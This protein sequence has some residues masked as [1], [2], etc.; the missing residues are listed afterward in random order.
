MA[1]VFR[2]WAFVALV[3]VLLLGSALAA[4]EADGRSKA[5]V[6]ISAAITDDRVV[7][8]Q[9]RVVRGKPRYRVRLEQRTHVASAGRV[10]P[11]W[12]PL[13]TS[14][15]LGK[16]LRYVVSVRVAPSRKVALR[17]VALDG[18][19]EVL[20]SRVIEI[21]GIPAVP[22]AGTGTPPAEPISAAGAPFAGPPAPVAV[23]PSVEPETSIVNGPSGRTSSTSATFAYAGGPG[24][25]CRVD[26]APFRSCP[27]GSFT[28][29]GL[30]D[31]PHT[32]EA[33]SV[34]DLGHADPTPAIRA[35]EI[36]TTAPETRAT[37]GPGPVTNDVGP[38]FRFASND[39]DGVVTYECRSDANGAFAPCP[40]D[41][42]TAAAATEGDHRLEV[43]AVDDVGNVDPTPLAYRWRLDLT[44]PDVRITDGPAGP[45]AQ[46]HATFAFDADPD[47]AR[48]ECR[49]DAAAFAAC[50]RGGTT[51]AGLDQGEHR[52]EVR[53]TDEAG[54]V[55]PTSVARTWLVDTLGPDTTLTGGPPPRSSTTSSTFAL[56]SPEAS[57]TRFECSLDGADFTSCGP[58]EHAL[59]DLAHGAHHLRV[60][61]LDALGN[62]DATPASQAF[63][64]DLRAPDTL[65]AEA[66]PEV[67]GR[68]LA[69]F[70]FKASPALDVERF[71]CRLDDGEWTRCSA[72]GFQ[73]EGLTEGDHHLEVRAT[74]SS[75]NVDATPAIHRWRVDLTAPDTE[76]V[77]APESTVATRTVRVQYRSADDDVHHFECAIDAG[78]F[79]PCGQ[80]TAVF[81][82]LTDGQ[83]TA[84]IRAVDAVGNTD[85]T[86]A[87]ATW[88]V[89]TGD[90]TEVVERASDIARLFPSA[91]RDAIPAA[92]VD[93][94]VG[95]LV[96]AGFR[97]EGGVDGS[98]G[99]S[100]ATGVS[101]AE[102]GVTLGVVPSGTSEAVGVAGDDAVLYADN[103]GKHVATRP[104]GDKA[105]EV[106]EVVPE[107]TRTA[108]YDLQVP[109]GARL[110]ELPNGDI[111]VV[112][113]AQPPVPELE[114]LHQQVQDAE[115][116]V[117][118][119]TLESVGDAQDEAGAYDQF[120]TGLA[121]AEGA[122]VPPAPT[123]PAPTREELEDAAGEVPAYV[124]PDATL[125]QVEA[126][127]EE[128]SR[129]LDPSDLRA[130]DH[131]AIAQVEELT[132]QARALAEELPALEATAVESAASGTFDRE[133]AALLSEQLVAEARDLADADL[134]IGDASAEQLRTAAKAVEAQ[135]AVEGRVVGLVSAPMSKMEDG[136]PLISTL[137]VTGDRSVEVRI[138]DGVQGNS[139]VD[140]LFVPIAAFVIRTAVQRYAPVVIRAASQHAVK[141]L[142]RVGS[143]ASRATTTIVRTVRVAQQA[144]RTAVQTAVRAGSRAVQNL[145]GAAASAARTASQHAA[146]VAEAARQEAARRIRVMQDEIRV[147]L[148]RTIEL[149]HAARAVER[150]RLAQLAEQARVFAQKQIAATVSR[151]I[152]AASTARR[153]L[154]E[155]TRTVVLAIRTR[156][157]AA[158]RFCAAARLEGLCGELVEEALGEAEERITDRLDG[159]AGN[160]SSLVSKC[161]VPAIGWAKGRGA[162]SN[163]AAES[164]DDTPVTWAS[165]LLVEDIRSCVEEAVG[166]ALELGAGEPAGTGVGGSTTRD[167]FPSA[168]ELRQL[169]EDALNNAQRV[170]NEIKANFD[171][172]PPSAP[173]RQAALVATTVPS[174]IQANGVGYIQIAAVNQ[175]RALPLNDT[176]IEVPGGVPW[177]HAGNVPGHADRLLLTDENADGRWDHGEVVNAVIEVRPPTMRSRGVGLSFGFV[178][179]GVSYSG[180]HGMSFTV[181][182]PLEV[183][184]IS[185]LLTNGPTQMR[186][187]PIPVRLTTQPWAYCGRRGCNI[188]GTER[189]TGQHYH[190]AV[191]RTTGEYTT[192]GDNRA[193]D[194]SGDDGNPQRYESSEYYGVD[195]GWTYGLVSWVWIHP[196][197]RGGLG[198]PYC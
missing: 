163:I 79:L 60:R 197:D 43:R 179:G 4:R 193:G 114:D 149:R 63:V 85:E 105:F 53:A 181:N 84:S 37:Q 134:D 116:Q 88:S 71:E 115:A 152:N 48:V 5:R 27:G 135:G 75:G 154:Q 7:R 42:H 49:L 150:S 86:V 10:V 14:G 20:A 104:T 184:E 185:N 99:S 159:E 41:G 180:G 67:S 169:L 39:G 176:F 18:R 100:L 44:P 101:V 121:R 93:P 58:D 68:P 94:R 13:K 138:P 8:A 139:V 174:H 161:V 52:L 196:A 136:E 158:R 6:E 190:H 32:F 126:A 162:V 110:E 147:A 137:E 96:G 97:M 108:R 172:P 187:D 59:S 131:A 73:A 192:N 80:D 189:T 40:A 76:V 34:D 122:P 123:G 72:A 83:H 120:A 36:D 143:A 167:L 46:Q 64:T 16:R 55:G 157:A 62:A 92:G 127:V 168:A 19:R 124:D 125:E 119:Q 103:E 35:W 113:P 12:V 89:T 198:L 11:I 23:R 2:G 166:E 102:S 91:F 106:L 95:Q 165:T 9:G 66:P 56:G 25:L 109:A 145:R 111:A 98:I 130:E 151:V 33:R 90:P 191:C 26:A 118:A 148:Q 30:S 107:G 38:R 78:E 183:L 69:D 45:V 175:G 29:G 182:G 3:G 188:N 74:D 82:D 164:T 117:T 129:G 140:P 177:I 17:A 24:F 155:I 21:R 160:G 146:R 171:P 1:G 195:L 173:E 70:V 81:R 77:K 28:I 87:T 170:G 128:A 15:A 51:L 57:V 141:V 144:V 54:N 132:T 22:P 178:S 61:A 194:P 186:E 156:I 112:D 142:S 31:G 133:T 47:T 65:V 50:E 153:V